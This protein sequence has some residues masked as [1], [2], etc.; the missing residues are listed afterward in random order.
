MFLQRPK[1]NNKTRK[2]ALH[3]WRLSLGNSYTLAKAMC[4]R[5][6]Q[7][8]TG[9]RVRGEGR[10]R[11]N[12]PVTTFKPPVAQ[13]AGGIYINIYIYIC[14]YL[15]WCNFIPHCEVADLSLHGVLISRRQLSSLPRETNPSPA[16]LHAPPLDAFRASAILPHSSSKKSH[17]R[18]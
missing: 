8:G 9:S 5:D 11:G 17:H 1:K 3:F 6:T 15:Y 16:D 7:R 13:G 2:L 4:T 18:K 10:E 14:L 12:L